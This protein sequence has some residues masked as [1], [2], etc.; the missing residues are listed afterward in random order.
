MLYLSQRKILQINRAGMSKA[1]DQVA[2]PASAPPP[3]PAQ[4]QASAPAPNPQALQPVETDDYVDGTPLGQNDNS[5][6]IKLSPTSIRNLENEIGAEERN[7][8]KNRASLKN[9]KLLA[10]FF[11]FCSVVIGIGTNMKYGPGNMSAFESLS[12]KEGLN[13]SINDPLRGLNYGFAA[14]GFTIPII[15]TLVSIICALVKNNEINKSLRNNKLRNIVKN[16]ID[17]AKDS[18][19]I[20][21]NNEVKK[22]VEGAP[23]NDISVNNAMT[24]A[25]VVYEQQKQNKAIIRKSN[26]SR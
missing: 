21:N 10:G 11:A 6:S 3:A 23:R 14:F 8:E 13:G 24:L 1:S 17:I 2:V 5:Y 20:T 22:I 15:G 25:E 9:W 19:I 26:L 12:G 4:P 7:I 18:E 16:G